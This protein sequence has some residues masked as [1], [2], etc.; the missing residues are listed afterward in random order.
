MKK[1]KKYI[2]LIERL[3]LQNNEEIKEIKREL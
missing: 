1:K 3:K 2:S